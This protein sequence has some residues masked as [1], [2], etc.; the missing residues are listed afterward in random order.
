MRDTKYHFKHIYIQTTQER[1]IKYRQTE[2][3]EEKEKMQ[4]YFNN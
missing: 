2:Q 3:I 1:E 4:T